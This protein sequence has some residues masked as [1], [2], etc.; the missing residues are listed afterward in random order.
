[1]AKAAHYPHVERICDLESQHSD[2]DHPN[3]LIN[4]S[5]CH[6]RAIVK[7]SSK[8]AHNLVSNDHSVC[9]VIIVIW[10]A[11]KI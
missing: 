4:Y 3:N 7:M 10:I 1:M 2:P 9:T 6:G 5:L 8:S 11:T